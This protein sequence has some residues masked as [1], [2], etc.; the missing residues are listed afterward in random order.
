LGGLPWG[1]CQHW[2]WVPQ[3]ALRCPYSHFCCI[4][5]RPTLLVNI[6]AS[7]HEHLAQFLFSP[8]SLH[9]MTAAFDMRIADHLAWWLSSADEIC[10]S[11]FALGR[12]IQY[13]RIVHCLVAHHCPQVP[14][15]STRLEC[16]HDTQTN[17]MAGLRQAISVCRAQSTE[18]LTMKCIKQS[19]M[20]HTAP[21]D[22]SAVNDKPALFIAI[23]SCMAASSWLAVRSAS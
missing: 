20:H 12:K 23:R 16:I 22:L 14:K 19:A 2:P 9:R 17:S 21:T 7:A 13:L 10:Q 8:N 18:C 1:C 11:E 6:C 5:A 4:S 15:T 3:H